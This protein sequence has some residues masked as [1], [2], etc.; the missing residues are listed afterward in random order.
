MSTRCDGWWAFNPPQSH[1]GHKGL[2]PCVSTVTTQEQLPER[3]ISRCGGSFRAPNAL[4]PHLPVRPASRRPA[5]RAQVCAK[6][7]GGS[8]LAPPP[9]FQSGFCETQ[10][11]E[12]SSIWYHLGQDTSIWNQTAHL[13]LVP[14][15][16]STRC[17]GC[18]S[19][20]QTQSRPSIG[21][22]SLRF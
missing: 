17:S 10:N 22:D 14:C 21:C 4:P 19:F 6:P 8:Q 13:L 1:T 12:W 18:V 15:R 3:P 16:T 5:Q 7:A 11:G 20:E 9:G 2:M